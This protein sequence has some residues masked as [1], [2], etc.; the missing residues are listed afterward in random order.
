MKTLTINVPIPLNHNAISIK[1][2]VPIKVLL[3]DF[4]LKPPEWNMMAIR[5]LFQLPNTK[6]SQSKSN[7]SATSSHTLT[8][9][10]LQPIPHCSTVVFCCRCLSVQALD[11]WGVLVTHSSAA[12]TQHAV[13]ASLTCCCFPQ[14]LPPRLR[15][16]MSS[17][18][19]THAPHVKCK[20]PPK[21]EHAQS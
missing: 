11:T 4:I 9:N 16:P 17:N 8:S 1:Q 14:A 19:C 21:A 6:R 18:M 13:L 2:T 3:D 5:F 7:V 20:P 12:N 15:C 10:A